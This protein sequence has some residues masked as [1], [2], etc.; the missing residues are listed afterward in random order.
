MNDVVDIE[1]AEEMCCTSSPSEAEAIGISPTASA[2][3]RP[4]VVAASPDGERRAQAE[5][6]RTNLSGAGGATRA[7]A[8]LMDQQRGAL[9][10]PVMRN[11]KND[12][13]PGWLRKESRTSP[14]TY[15]YTHVATGRAQLHLPG[16]VDPEKEVRS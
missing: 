8:K 4:S 14:G 3:V 1:A 16:T 9:A 15:Y 11:D 2:A 7:G 5:P 12:L 6:A 13:P 10:L